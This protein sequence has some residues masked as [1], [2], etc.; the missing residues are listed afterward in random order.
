ME[1][2]LFFFEKLQFYKFTIITNWKKRSIYT[3]RHAT[4]SSEFI[5]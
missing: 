1:G 5:N 2:D 4:G 3:L